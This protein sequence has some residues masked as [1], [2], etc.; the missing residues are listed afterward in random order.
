MRKREDHYEYVATYVD[1]LTLAMKDPEE[2]VERMK[3]K[4]YNLDFKGTGEL[5]FQLGCGFERD[6]DGTLYMEASK[7]VTRMEEAYLRYFGQLPSTKAKQPLDKNDHPELDTSELLEE[8]ETTIYQSLI[9]M[10]QWAI[11]IGRFDI[12]TAIMTL[13]SFR[14]MPRRGHLDQ[15][16]RLYGYLR[17]FKHFKIRF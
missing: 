3:K 9:G 13:S 5:K 4:P 1:D 11:S 7:Y 17:A 14:A 2:L 16:K 10:A 6:K 15:I 12:Q 8:E